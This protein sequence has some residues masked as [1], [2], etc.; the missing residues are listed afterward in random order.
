MRFRYNDEP[1]TVN[2]VRD[3]LTMAG[4]LARIR[5]R[6]LTG[7]YDIALPAAN[8]VGAPDRE[9]AGAGRMRIPI[10]FQRRAAPV[11]PTN[12]IIVLKWHHNRDNNEVV[13]FSV[14]HE[15]IREFMF[16]RKSVCLMRSKF[17]RRAVPRF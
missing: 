14:L 6:A 17:G 11:L 13:E 8:E 9:S 16:L 10:S 5:W 2:F 4:D 1:T 7:A 15:D 12:N 3:A